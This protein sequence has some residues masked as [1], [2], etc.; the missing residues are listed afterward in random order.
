[1]A[2]WDNLEFLF[3][4]TAISLRSFLSDF[5][6]PSLTN[7]LINSSSDEIPKATERRNL[8]IERSILLKDSSLKIMAS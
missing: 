4:I 2:C 5:D 7:D 8:F 1:M 3:R 6:K